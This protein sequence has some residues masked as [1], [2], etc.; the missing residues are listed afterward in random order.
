MNAYAASGTDEDFHRGEKESSKQIWPK[1]I[2]RPELSNPMLGTISTP[3]FYGAVYLPGT[4]GTSG[5]M[6]INENAQV[7][8]VDGEAIEG[9]YACG[10]CTAALSGGTYLGGGGTLGPGSVMA[11]IAARH[12]MGA[13]V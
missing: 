1:G 9:L 2:D 4:C 11:Y 3:P 8:N 12:A 6:S 5:G 10:N 13:A 7:L